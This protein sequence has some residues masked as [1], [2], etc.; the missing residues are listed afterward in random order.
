M[1]I[2]ILIVEDTE[3]QQF[4]AKEAF[5]ESTL[6]TNLRD[7]KSA[8]Q[9][10]P[11]AVLSDL[12]IPSGLTESEEAPLK[13]DILDTLQNY[14]KETFGLQ[15]SRNSIVG[16]VLSTVV[17]SLGLKTKE[18]FFAHFKDDALINTPLFKRSIEEGIERYK[19][20]QDYLLLHSR[21]EKGEYQL[22][23]GI[24]VYE[25]CR[26]LNI[27]CITV[28]SAYH[29]GPEFEPFSRRLGPYVDQLVNGKKQWKQAYELLM[30]K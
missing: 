20:E 15:G 10:Q 18:E 26:R 22:P 29:H 11:K 7:A 5:P 8:L 3:L 14:V 12:Y 23:F 24:L 30:R 27:P 16:R 6:V 28:T 21:M 2:D 9:Q 4:A 25:E 17:D 13:Q 19:Q 1:A